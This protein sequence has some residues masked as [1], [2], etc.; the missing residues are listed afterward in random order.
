MTAFAQACAEHAAL[1]EKLGALEEV[2]TYVGEALATAISRGNKVMLI[3]NGGSATDADH[4][5]AEFTG[6]FQMDRAG[7]PAMALTTSAAALTAIANDYGYE[8]VFER[9]VEAFGVPGDV[10]IAI[11]TSGN[12]ES[13]NRAV[14]LAR[15]REIV[16]VALT[17]RDGGTLARL[18]E[19]IVLVPGDVTARIQEM[20]L[21]IGHTWCDT[22]ERALFGPAADDG[23][24]D[25]S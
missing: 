18:A 16:T 11:S 21:L 8:S 25:Q 24:Q 17:G 23:A 9:Q 10:L 1:L 20:H 6:R 22:V 7:M 14:A 15:D 5:A 4:L 19:I 13:V 3:G 12:S 2:V